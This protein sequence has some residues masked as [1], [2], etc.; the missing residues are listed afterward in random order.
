MKHATLALMAAAVAATLLGWAP[1]A[2]AWAS[3]NRFGGATAHSF[4]DTA[5]ANRWGGSTQHVAGEGTEHT[6][7]Y[8]GSTAHSAY[9]GTEHT[10][11]TG[12]TTYGKA[13][14]GAVSTTPGGASYYHPPAYGAYPAYPA[15]HPPVAVPYYSTGCMGCAAAAG[16][17]VGMATGAAIAS[18]A[19][20][21]ATQNAY[22]AGVATGSANT[23]AA[24]QQGYAAGATTAGAPLPGTTRTT[25][26]VT[27]TT[28]PV[29]YAMGAS[30]AALPAGAMTIQKNGQTYY[31]SGNTWFLPAFGAN[32]VHYT[33]VAAP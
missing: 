13:G 31:L 7:A 1:R 22:A 28:A 23:N 32:G 8:G 27:T 11:T 20:A 19:N 14:Y 3:A 4:G 2:D 5:H 6:N 33:V 29:S 10:S 25:T 30:Y 9:G 24:Y 12:T 18:S 21:A 15:Y 26:T 16:A 17:V